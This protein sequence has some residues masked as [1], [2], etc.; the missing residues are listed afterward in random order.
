MVSA[1]S[2]GGIFDMGESVLPVNRYTVV[3]DIV[4]KPGATLTLKSGTELNFLNGIGMLVL[5]ELRVEG[6][7]YSPVNFRLADKGYMRFKRQINESLDDFTNSTS[8]QAW[9]IQ[10][11]L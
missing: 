7:N 2:L 8:N 9:V 10:K 6:A 5:G 3:N 4:V 1:E 11:I